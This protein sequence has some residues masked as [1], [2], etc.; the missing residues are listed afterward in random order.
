MIKLPYDKREATTTSG[1]RLGTPVVTKRG[2]GVEEMNS[3]SAL[4]NAVL[5]RVKIVSDIEYGIDESFKEQ[6]REKIEDL[7]SKFAVC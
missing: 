3:I 6:M 1:I 5:K 2:M 4:I 7:C